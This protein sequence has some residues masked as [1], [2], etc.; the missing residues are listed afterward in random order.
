[1]LYGY[2]PDTQW[3]ALQFYEQVS[4]G[5]ICEDYERGPPAERKRFY[6]GLETTHAP[7]RALTKEEKSLAM[8]YSGGVC[9]IKVTL[10]SREAAER[11]IAA[12]PHALQGH[13]VYAE[14]FKGQ[15]PDV[16]EPILVRDED[17]E[18][19]LLGAARPPQHKSATLGASSAPPLEL[20]SPVQQ[21]G[22]STLPRSFVARESSQQ[23]D[24]S[25]AST[26][27]ASSATATIV[28][29]GGVRRRDAG[30]ELGQVVPVHESLATFSRFPDK[31]RTVLRP[32]SEALLPQMT[33]SERVVKSLREGGWIPGDMIGTVVPRLESGEF[34]WASASFYW[35]LFYWIDCTLG[36]D[37]CGLK[38]G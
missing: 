35:K 32:A 1:M 17:R 11:A 15:G 6:S 30:A 8:R 31:P 9:W 18:T 34:D 4:G 24:A 16:D 22:S 7:R 13:W 3:A 37:L 36:T 19:G 12:S 14:A 33:W 20:R 10:D 2:S 25:V 27:T 5:M 21:R 29:A 38:E 23:D 28:D 26:A